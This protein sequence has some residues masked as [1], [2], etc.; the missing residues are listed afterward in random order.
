MQYHVL[1]EM[2]EIVSDL[3]SLQIQLK[4]IELF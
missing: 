2:C 4:F 3:V 1:L